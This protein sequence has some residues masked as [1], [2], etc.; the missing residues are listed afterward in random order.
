MELALTF[1]SFGDL[2]AIG[3]LIKDIIVCLDDCRGASKEYQDLVQ[4]LTILGTAIQEVDL[5]FRGQRRRAVAP[6]LCESASKSIAQIQRTLESFNEKLQK[7]RPSLTPGGSGN[8]LKDV[9]RKIQFKMDEKDMEKF[10][11]EVTGYTVALRILMDAMT[12]HSLDRNHDEVINAIAAAGGETRQETKRELES[13]SRTLMRCVN[14]IGRHLVEKISSLTQATLEIRRS[15]SQIASTVLSISLELSSFRL[16]LTSLQ[17]HAPEDRYYFVVQDAIGREFPIHLNTITSWDAFAF[18]LSEKFRGDKGARRVRHGRYRLNEQATGREIDQTRAWEKAFRPH[19]KIAMS[20]LCKDPLVKAKH[21]TTGGHLA[22]CPWCKTVSGSDTGTQVQCQ[23]CNMF[24]TRIVEL[25]DMALPPQPSPGRKAPQF[26]RVSFDVQS[27]PDWTRTK[28]RRQYED[29]YLDSAQKKHK[30]DS[31]DNQKR[32]RDD[33]DDLEPES[34]DE[35]VSGLVR[36]AV[37]SRRKRIKVFR[38]PKQGPGT[39]S[40]QSTTAH[41]PPTEMDLKVPSAY[42]LVWQK[43]PR[44]P[45]LTV[46]S[47]ADFSESD[48]DDI[49]GMH[50]GLIQQEDLQRAKEA[51]YY[52]VPRDILFKQSLGSLHNRIVESY[53]LEMSTVGGQNHLFPLQFHPGPP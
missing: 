4:S 26:G 22:S 21:E 40:F 31:S 25:E 44:S 15:A 16:L 8:R 17:Q 46:T 28:K 32:N 47:T 48:G 39:P 35:D 24:F 30:H 49:D 11:G 5:I 2:L 13:T 1:G 12:L 23:S 29:G 18:V 50:E 41:V 34:D 36:V 27:S 43:S 3:I 42:E 6:R 7:F 52:F 37:V 38:T 10:K 20:L 51:D 53:N 19:Q 45:N 14:G 33:D 9:A